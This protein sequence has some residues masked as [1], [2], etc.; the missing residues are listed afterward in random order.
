V[1]LLSSVS[2]PN[3]LPP[4][5]RSRAQDTAEGGDPHASVARAV[6]SDGTRVPETAPK[7]DSAVGATHTDGAAALEASFATGA[8]TIGGAPARVEPAAGA[9]SSRMQMG[10][11][12]PPPHDDD[13]DEFEV[14]MGRPCL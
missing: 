12:A 5:E 1:L 3:V 2:N 7:A 8:T 4:P 13:D 6:H 10:A 14:V 11:V 9:S